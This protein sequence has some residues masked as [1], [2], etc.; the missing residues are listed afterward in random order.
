MAGHSPVGGPPVEG[1][2]FH[3]INHTIPLQTR[4]HNSQFS[5]L[6]GHK[7]ES[8]K[9]GK[10]SN[11]KTMLNLCSAILRDVIIACLK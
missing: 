3:Q 7:G 10:G 5:F 4:L 1:Y 6:K 2:G 11:G 8:E 9:G